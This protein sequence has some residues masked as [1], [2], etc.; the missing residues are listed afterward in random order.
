MEQGSLLAPG[1]LELA[2]IKTSI[3]PATKGDIPT[4]IQ[5]QKND[6]F[7]HQYYLT[8]ERLERLFDRGEQFFVATLDGKSLGFASVDF[9]KRATAH[10]LC[11][12]QDNKKKGIGSLLMKTLI[13]EAKSRGYTRLC[14]YVEANSTK[15]VFLKKHGFIQVGYHKNRYGNSQDASIWEVDL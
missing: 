11:V 6:G 13:Q 9:E 5:L 4:L 8:Q 10:F 3:R 1:N 14:S 2:G 15:E 12:D 7:P